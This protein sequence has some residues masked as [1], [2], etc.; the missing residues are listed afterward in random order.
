MDFEKELSNLTQSARDTQE[1][2]KLHSEEEQKKTKIL[3]NVKSLIESTFKTVMMYY[4]NASFETTHRVENGKIIPIM[5]TFRC[6]FLRFKANNEY[7]F[8]YPA[9]IGFKVLIPSLSKLQILNCYIIEDYQT[10]N[11]F[12]DFVD[13]FKTLDSSNKY[14]YDGTLDEQAIKDTIKETIINSI[15]EIKLNFQ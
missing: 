6:C 10:R 12:A 5:G 8:K 3:L 9:T 7:G 15:K 14:L 11:I 2:K 1:Q 13:K 4:S